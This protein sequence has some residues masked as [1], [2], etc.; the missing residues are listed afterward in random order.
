VDSLLGKGDEVV[1]LDNL[2]LGSEDMIRH[3]YGNPGFEF[4]C[5]DACDEK[6][7][8]VLFEKHRF[9]RVYHLAANSDIQKGGQDPRID[10]RNTFQ[11]TVSLLDAMRKHGVKEFLF[12]SSSAVYGDK[13]GLL[14]ETV[15]RLC[16]ISYYGASKLAS[17]AF[18]SAY[19]SMN[20]LKANILRFPNVVGPRL[21]HGAVFDFIAK[22][23]RDPCCLEILGD[24]TQDKPYLYVADLIDA[25]LLMKYTPGAEVFNVGVGT[26]TTV[27]RIADIV[28]EEMGLKNVSYKFTG[29]PIGW[30]GDVPKF[31]YDL[32]NI[33]AFGWRAKHTSDEA[34]RLAARA[35]LKGS[36]KLNE[37]SCRSI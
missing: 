15:G 26:S 27:R 19:A 13:P 1:C 33:H 28:C 16:P 25:M 30:L 31:Q 35:S 20:G 18:L 4:Y 21:T 23:K 3:C 24:G 7:L 8:D 5:F 22:L 29:G 6:E 37:S 36:F 2:C 34:V 17:E 12:A 14:N 9:Q 10:F 32:S 11:T